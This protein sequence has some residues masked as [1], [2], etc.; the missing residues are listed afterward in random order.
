MNPDSATG[1]C[2]AHGSCWPRK[3]AWCAPGL[4]GRAAWSSPGPK[5][6]SCYA[7]QGGAPEQNQLLLCLPAR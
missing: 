1:W 6:C 7:P 2:T 4:P 5:L 3:A